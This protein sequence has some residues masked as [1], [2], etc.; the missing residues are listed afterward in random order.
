[1]FGCETM[2]KILML[3]IIM[4]TGVLLFGCNEELKNYR[5]ESINEIEA[6][7]HELDKKNLEY[8][9]LFIESEIEKTKE[10]INNSKSTDEI[11]LS[12]EKCINEINDLILSSENLTKIINS[13]CVYEHYEEGKGDFP[14]MAFFLGNIKELYFVLIYG[15]TIKTPEEYNYLFVTNHGMYLLP[16][17]YTSKLG[18]Y[19]NGEYYSISDNGTKDLLD[20]NDFSKEDI[21]KIVERYNILIDENKIN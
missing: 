7:Y 8:S 2:K 19:Y 10:L 4:F 16:Y 6:Y 20:K 1:M 9:R 12:K 3:L 13:Y 15:N 11:G 18:I 21:D 17:L 14:R 5:D